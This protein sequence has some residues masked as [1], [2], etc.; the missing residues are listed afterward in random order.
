MRVELSVGITGG[1]EIRG[2]ECLRL[3]SYSRCSVLGA[4]G[5][6]PHTLQQVGVATIRA[7][8]VRYDSHLVGD[9]SRYEWLR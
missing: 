1:D 5:W 6:W 7:G 9:E 2:K 4:P 8:R 3:F